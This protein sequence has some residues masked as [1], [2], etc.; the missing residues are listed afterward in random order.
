MQSQF[1]PLAALPERI[2][3]VIGKRLAIL[4]LLQT[5]FGYIKTGDAAE[6]KPEDAQLLRTLT[7]DL[8]TAEARAAIL[9]TNSDLSRV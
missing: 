3:A 7:D 4:R 9:L 1:A 6:F 5:V 8:K 2:D